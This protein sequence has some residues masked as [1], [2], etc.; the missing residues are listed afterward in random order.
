MQRLNTGKTLQMANDTRLKI[1]VLCTGNSARSIMAEALFN[2]LGASLFRAYSA[3]SQ[4]TGRVNPLALEQIK[5][6]SPE[7]PLQVSSKS[8]HEFNK[9][10]APELDLV[11]T[12][13]D[14]AAGEECPLFFN[15]CERVHW[16]LP[17]PAG[18]SNKLEEERAAFASCF[19][20]L[21]FRIHALRDRYP[22]HRTDVDAGE[23]IA[24]MRE[25]ECETTA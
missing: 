10:S 11:L 3:G 25:F 5:T 1:L 24:A 21:R 14:Q 16:G 2:S 6:L 20:E 22:D 12:V 8:W 15:D 4:P 19:E 17:D 23:L 13:C 7:Y 18:C 9:P